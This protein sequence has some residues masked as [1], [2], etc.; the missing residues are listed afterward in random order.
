M[1]QIL[2]QTIHI[3]EHEY[4]NTFGSDGWRKSIRKSVNGNHNYRFTPVPKPTTPQ[5]TTP[6]V[7]AINVAAGLQ[8]GSSPATPPSNPPKARPAPSPTTGAR[9]TTG[10]LHLQLQPVPHKRLLTPHP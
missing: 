9:S 7:G 3:A 4:T 5:S 6:T 10:T 1:T 2:L 8:P